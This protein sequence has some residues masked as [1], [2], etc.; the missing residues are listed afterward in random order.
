MGT[1]LY[2]YI[3]AGGELGLATTIEAGASGEAVIDAGDPWFTGIYLPAAVLFGLGWLSL[4]T[5]VYR[6]EVL[7]RELTWVV[8]GALVVLAVAP[9]IPTGWGEYLI[10]V[11]LIVAAWPLAY[12]M[13]LDTT[14]TPA[15]AAPSAPA[16][17]APPA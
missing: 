11:G 15:P 8:I 4:A 9:F 14:E 17:P 6:S 16:A 13:W 10:G 5:A 7:G 12:Q 2:A 3:A 1:V